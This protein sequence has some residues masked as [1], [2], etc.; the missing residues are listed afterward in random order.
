MKRFAAELFAA[1]L[2][3]SLCAQQKADRLALVDGVIG[4]AISAGTVPGAVLA[5]MRGDDIVWL[6]AYGNRSV[7]P[8]VEPMTTDTMFDLASCSKVMGTTLAFMKLVENGQVR[9]E[10]NVS[11][12]IPGF[13]P[14]TDPGTGEQVQIKVRDLMTHSSGLAPYIDVESFVKEY[15]ENCPGLLEEYIATKVKRNFRPGTDCM[16]SCL[17][18]ITLQR[19]LEK[20]TGQKLYEYAHENIFAPLALKHTCYFPLDPSLPKVPGID[21]DALAALCAPTTVQADG[22]PLVARVHDPIARRIMSGNS[23]NAGMFSDARDLCTICSAIMKCGEGILKPATVRLMTTVPEENDPKVGRALG[24]DTKNDFT[25]CHTGYTGTS[26]E[27]DLKNHTAIILLTNRVHPE[28]K[29]SVRDLRLKVSGI[30]ASSLNED[31]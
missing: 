31:K 28:D 25:I 15:G 16:Y 5:V 21:Y 29:G 12:Y 24:W 19:I 3:L 23:G 27:I 10:D 8:S 20:V 22:L 18:F 9:I 13:A 30:V 4:E 14:W 6:K 11:L 2:C 17:N 7:T 1:A 26:V